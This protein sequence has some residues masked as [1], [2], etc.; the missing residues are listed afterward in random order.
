MPIP[1][2]NNVHQVDIVAKAVKERHKLD[3]KE[4]VELDK[5]GG[6]A[7]AKLPTN[8]QWLRNWEYV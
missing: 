3:L 1:G 5:A 4:K 2:I 6:E 8:Y 7:W